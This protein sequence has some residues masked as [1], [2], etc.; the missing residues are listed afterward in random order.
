MSQNIK[1]MFLYIF[2]IGD[3]SFICIIISFKKKKNKHWIT[4][5][6]HVLADA[7]DTEAKKAK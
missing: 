1:G 6:E 4:V 5:E 7:T 2:I 3:F